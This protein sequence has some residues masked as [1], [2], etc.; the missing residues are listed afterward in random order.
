[1]SNNVIY[2]FLRTYT[3][4]SELENY[5]NDLRLFPPVPD[6][7]EVQIVI[8][9]EDQALTFT[10]DHRAFVSAI[11]SKMKAC[12]EMEISKLKKQLPVHKWSNNELQMRI[13][14][15]N[16]LTDFSQKMLIGKIV[17]N[18]MEM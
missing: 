13:Y 5:K 4:I 6:N 3:C 7:D 9:K 8:P 12:R 14:H 11:K 1:M 15:I 18:K 10:V 17:I 2:F 16:M